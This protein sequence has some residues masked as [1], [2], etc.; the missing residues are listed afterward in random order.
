MS[1]SFDVSS[2]IGY[3]II[4]HAILFFAIIVSTSLSQRNLLESAL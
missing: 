4:Y 2:D 1:P 3:N